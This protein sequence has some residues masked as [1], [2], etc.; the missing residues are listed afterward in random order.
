MPTSRYPNTLFHRE[1]TWR[2]YRRAAAAAV[3]TR[4]RPWLL[5]RGSLTE[6]LVAASNYQFRVEVLK[7]QLEAPRLSECQALGIKPRS[8][9]MIREVV[10]YGC[11]TPWVY[12]RSAIPIA[13]LRGPLAFLRKPD[14]RPLGAMLF[15]NPSMRRSPMEIACLTPQNSL[16]SEQLNDIEQPVWGRRSVF[17]VGNKPLLVSEI[18]LPTFAP[19][20]S[21][22]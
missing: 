17:R 4:L 13:S 10:L 1:N 22:P 3:P 19:E 18:F 8:V 20:S 6:R 21:G 11:G 5:D 14:G 15:S 16:L 2:R 7:H 9:A 12:A